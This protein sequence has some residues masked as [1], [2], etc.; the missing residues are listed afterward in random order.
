MHGPEELARLTHRHVMRALQEGG[1]PPHQPPAP[2]RRYRAAE[3]Q[4][5]CRTLRGNET[6]GRRQRARLP[7]EGAGIKLAAT[8]LAHR[9]PH[10][11]RDHHAGNAEDQ[12]TPLASRCARPPR[13]PPANRA[14]PPGTHRGRRSCEPSVAA[15]QE[16]C[17]RAS[18]LREES[19]RPRRFR[20]RIGQQQ[21][22]VVLSETTEGG[23]PGPDGE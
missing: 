19:P 6:Q 21:L 16:T 1:G 4:M 23:H 2:E 9:Q 17:R 20:L 10:D 12:K 5:N 14:T 15:P 11:Q 13:P 8:R 7:A 3:Q 18:M 22:P